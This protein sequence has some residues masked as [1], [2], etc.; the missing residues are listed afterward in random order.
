MSPGKDPL[1]LGP[2]GLNTT[3]YRSTT[4]IKQNH[5]TSQNKEKQLHD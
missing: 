4:K 1:Y 5:L 2:K 3:N